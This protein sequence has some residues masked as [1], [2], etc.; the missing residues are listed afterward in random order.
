MFTPEWITFD[1]YDTLIDF[2]IDATT[3]G[4]L[5]LRADGIDADAFLAT[6][7]AFRVE[8]EARPEYWP[9]RVVL[10]NS[11]ERAMEPYGLAYRDDDGA[12]LVAAVPTFGPHVD[13][14]P[15]LERLRQRCKLAIIS[16]SDD[17]LIAGNVQ[18]IGVPFDRIITSQQA[19]AYQPSLAIFRC[20]LNDMHCPPERAMHV[21]QDFWGDM[22]PAA[23][24]GFG[25]RVW[26]NRFDKTGDPAYAPDH[27]LSSLSNLPALIGAQQ[28]Q[29]K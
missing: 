15:A 18:R 9:Y 20:A 5:G 10:S 12:A 28:C 7:A 19:R 3:L 21:A 8:E 4:I 23:E 1:C 6:F 13:V 26:I 11:L 22:A 2:A 29:R 14:P 27:E 24:I 25:Q 16:N 17:D